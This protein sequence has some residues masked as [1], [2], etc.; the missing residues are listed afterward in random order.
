LARLLKGHSKQTEMVTYYWVKAS[1]QTRV[2]SQ[3]QQPATDH[4]NF[5]HKGTTDHNNK[6][7]FSSRD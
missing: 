1:R 5:Q 7:T 2:E 6:H 3:A 4:K